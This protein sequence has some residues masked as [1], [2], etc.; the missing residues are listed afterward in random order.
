MTCSIMLLST[1]SLEKNSY[2]FLLNK[3]RLKRK[4]PGPNLLQKI[5]KTKT[6]AEIRV[7]TIR[8]M[9]IKMIIETRTALMMTKDPQQERLAN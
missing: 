8:K 4:K 6:R 9:M 5:I 1:M 3:R 2:K 7:K